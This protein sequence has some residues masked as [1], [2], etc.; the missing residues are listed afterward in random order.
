MNVTSDFAQLPKEKRIIALGNFDGV[1]LGHQALLQT[2][3]RLSHELSGSSVAFIFNPH[4]SKVLG[5]PVSFI[6]TEDEKASLIMA[7]GVHTLFR[8]PFDREL[9][10]MSPADFVHSILLG[11]AQA[12]AVVVGFNYSFGRGGVG[13]PEYLSE[14]LAP[15]GVP[16][17][18]VHPVVCAGEAV[19]STRVRQ[20]IRQGE[21]D[22]V[23][24]LLGRPYSLTGAVGR[25]DQRGRRIGYPTANLAVDPERVLPPMG[26]YAVE[27]AGLGIGMANLGFRPSFPQA[28]PGLEVNIFDFQGDLYDKTLE[29]RFL[30]YIRGEQRFTGLLDLQLQLE[31]D[32]KA[33]LQMTGTT[34]P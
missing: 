6:T 13:T 34:Q 11:S 14:V 23:R 32:R 7:T 24:E 12:R 21:L 27:V 29:V 2:A 25:G 15:Y 22:M 30:S 3:V 8:M 26:V 19:S 18:V 10:V 9:A 28:T 17:I 1:H 31:R 20:Y 5:Y 4:P 33:I 16:V